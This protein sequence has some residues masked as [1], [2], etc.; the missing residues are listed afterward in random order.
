MTP[1]ELAGWLAAKKAYAARG[2]ITEVDAFDPQEWVR[3]EA[4]AERAC[5]EAEVHNQTGYAVLYE[6][7]ELIRTLTPV[8]S[9]DP[10]WRAR[11]D[12]LRQACQ[13][14]RKAADE[15]LARHPRP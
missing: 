14:A 1:L 13:Q 6:G 15:Y 3:L 12:E 7:G 11:D 4:V 2:R 5:H 9:D 10:E 8:S